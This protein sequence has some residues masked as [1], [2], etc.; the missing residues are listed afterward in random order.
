MKNGKTKR[1][2]YIGSI[3]IVVHEGD[4]LISHHEG[5]TFTYTGKGYY[6]NH[7]YRKDTEFARA[8]IARDM[9]G[10]FSLD[11]KNYLCRN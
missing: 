11:G 4:L 7:Q 6:L 5:C 3:S 9:V 8:A 1:V 2:G 10:D